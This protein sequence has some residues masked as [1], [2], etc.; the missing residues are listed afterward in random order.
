MLPTRSG[1]RTV[2]STVKSAVD[3]VNEK[4]IAKKN[5]I[6][7]ISGNLFLLMLLVERIPKCSKS[8]LFLTLDL[9][10]ITIHVFFY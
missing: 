2:K 7:I 6:V 3:M 1:K 10:F 8:E 9:W 5:V 4:L